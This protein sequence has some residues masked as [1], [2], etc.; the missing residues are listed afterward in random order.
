MSSSK[1]FCLIFWSEPAQASRCGAMLYS[2]GGGFRQGVWF[3]LMLYPGRL[4][5]PCAIVYRLLD[6]GQNVNRIILLN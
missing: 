4:P 6:L 5:I 2:K 1:F 3:L